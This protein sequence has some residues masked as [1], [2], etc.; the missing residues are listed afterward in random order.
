VKSV[1]HIFT[2][3]SALLHFGTR[4]NTL[5]KFFGSKRSKVKVTATALPK[6]A[7]QAEA[8]KA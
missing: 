6:K 8:Y 1:G 2:K 7:Q 3:L 5:I 4:M